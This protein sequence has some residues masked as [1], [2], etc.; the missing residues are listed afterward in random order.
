MPSIS[1]T[2]P[3][4]HESIILFDQYSV[5]MIG[6]HWH[7]YQM[8]KGISW[9]SAEALSG[10]EHFEFCRSFEHTGWL[11]TCPEWCENKPIV[12]IPRGEKLCLEHIEFLLEETDR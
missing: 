8:F 3:E 10:V 11:G 7:V 5:K 9:L 12:T 2:Q 6:E 1:E 4:Y